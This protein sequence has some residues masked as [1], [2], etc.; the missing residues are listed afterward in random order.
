MEGRCR[1]RFEDDH[2]PKPFHGLSI[3]AKVKY[4]LR[5]LH[6]AFIPIHPSPTDF[7]LIASSLNPGPILKFRPYVKAI[8]WKNSNPGCPILKSNGAIKGGLT[9]GGGVIRLWLGE[10]IANYFSYYGQGTSNS[11]K[12]RALM[13]GTCI[14]QL[15]EFIHFL[16]K[17]N[18]N[19]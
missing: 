19:L 17:L 10:Y 7:N 12:T 5:T 13:E 11:A 9:G 3:I 18:P 4:W 14:V 1:R 16:F 6:K 8:S 2:I 15:W